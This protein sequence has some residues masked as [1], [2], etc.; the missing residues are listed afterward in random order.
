M[1]DLITITEQLRQVRS[2]D[3]FRGANGKAIIRSPYFRKLDDGSLLFDF[4]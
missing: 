3:E 2:L 1:S 4:I